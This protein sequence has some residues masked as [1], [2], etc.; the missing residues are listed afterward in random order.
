MRAVR[1]AGKECVTSYVHGGETC[2]S[3]YLLCCVYSFCFLPFFF[4][5]S[6]F[7]TLCPSVV[8]RDVISVSIAGDY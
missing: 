6:F 5:F 4:L 1:S 2:C 7:C 3:A 8:F